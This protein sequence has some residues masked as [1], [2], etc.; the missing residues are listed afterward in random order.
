[1]HLNLKWF[2]IVFSTTSDRFNDS[3]FKDGADVVDDI[4]NTQACFILEL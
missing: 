3:H 4:L 2:L 1:M